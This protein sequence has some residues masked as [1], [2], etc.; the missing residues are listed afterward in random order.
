MLSLFKCKRLEYYINKL[1]QMIKSKVY[2]GTA[3]YNQANVSTH[4]GIIGLLTL[5][6]G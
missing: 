6:Q 4:K 2:I 5:K 3:I 1:C